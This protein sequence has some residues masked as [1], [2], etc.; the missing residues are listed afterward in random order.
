MSN[1]FTLPIKK[2]TRLTEK[3][4]QLSFDLSDELRASYKFIPG[5]YL[6]L[7]TSINGES[8]RR[9]YSICSAPDE[10]L[11]IAVKAIDQGVFSNYA[12]EQL[13]DGDVLEVHP[14]E[15]S[16]QL[17]ASNTQKK[18]VAFAAGSGITPVL[19][20]LKS[21]LKQAPES[22]F[23]LAYGNKSKAEAMFL[24][25]LKHLQSSYKERFQLIE[26]YSRTQ[27]DNAKFGR[28]EKP[29]VN[30][31]LKNMYKDVDF[32]AYFICGPEEMIEG[33]KKTLTENSVEKDK[34]QFELFYSSAEEAIETKDGMTSINVTVDDETFSFQMG[35]DEVI[36]DA[37]LAK[38]ID[39]PYSCQGGICSSCVAKIT[40]G[41][42]VMKK[43]Q[44]LTDEEVEEGLVLTCQ[45]H[46]TTPEIHVD[47]DDL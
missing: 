13:K 7:Q 43:N 47:Y 15:G 16:F 5:Q 36:L 28:I 24:D 41:K 39:A 46:P 29:F 44:I 42:A 10:D 26:I 19:S 33:V 34:I 31:V 23:V 27:E 11:A 20:M 17:E 38:D 37:I 32:D 18:Y 14:P 6:T 35:Q 8:V 9:S 30:Y 12:N 4:V 45:A 1:F 40:K 21:T 3:S 25:E 2:V 22:E